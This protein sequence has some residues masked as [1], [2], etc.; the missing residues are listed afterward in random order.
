M[1][2]NCVCTFPSNIKNHFPGLFRTYSILC[3][4]TNLRFWKAVMAVADTLPGPGSDAGPTLPAPSQPGSPNLSQPRS[5][6]LSQ[7][8][9][10]NLSQPRSPDP[11]RPG[12]PDAFPS[13]S[14]LGPD[15]GCP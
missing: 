15:T 6:N 12:Y 4:N 3:S 5:P 2:A 11:S 10:P 1:A 14:Y 13:G 7:P 9:S 8:R